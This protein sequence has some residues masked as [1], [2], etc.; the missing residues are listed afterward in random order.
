[1]EKRKFSKEKV[2]EILRELGRRKEIKKAKIQFAVG[3]ESRSDEG[4]MGNIPSCNDFPDGG[5]G[6]ISACD[7]MVCREPTEDII[8]NVASC[9]DEVCGG[10]AGNVSACDDVVCQDP[11]AD[12]DTIG[13]TSACGDW[14]CD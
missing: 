8:G 10:G 3:G 6:N 14:A 1:M 12:P 13:N 9:T 5:A 11:D 7:D 4:G 2:E